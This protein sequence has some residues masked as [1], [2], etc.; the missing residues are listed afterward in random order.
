MQPNWKPLE[1]KLG[2]ERCAGLVFMRANLCILSPREVVLFSYGFLMFG[3][4]R[5]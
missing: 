3:D 2:K 5:R 1:E 4:R